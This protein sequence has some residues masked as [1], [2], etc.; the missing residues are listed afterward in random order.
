MLVTMVLTG[1]MTHTRDSNNQA[2]AC[3][4][5]CTKS[6]L[7]PSKKCSRYQDPRAGRINRSPQND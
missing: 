3:T 7:S 6:L 2:A 5:P 4:I 1:F